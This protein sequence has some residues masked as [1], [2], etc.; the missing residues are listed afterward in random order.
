VVYRDRS[1]CPAVL[2]RLRLKFGV[3]RVGSYLHGL[4]QAITHRDLKPS[5]L[6]FKGPVL[7]I[8][9]MGQSLG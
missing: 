9:D 3:W 1:G 4:P 2:L 5:N 6:L 8:A 7:K